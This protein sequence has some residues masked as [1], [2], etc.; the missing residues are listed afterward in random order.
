[1]SDF[2]SL[3]IFDDGD[4]YPEVTQA[5]LERA[6]FRIGLNRA[7]HKRSATISLDEKP[8]EKGDE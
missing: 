1:M 6:K 3:D 8:R 4:E 2:S 7:P 5:D